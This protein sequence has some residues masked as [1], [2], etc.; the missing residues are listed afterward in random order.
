MKTQKRIKL[1]YCVRTKH[2]DDMP[3]K[4]PRKNCAFRGSGKF[5]SEHLTCEPN[6]CI[7]HPAHI[8]YCEENDIKLS[9]NF[10]VKFICVLS[11]QK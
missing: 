3:L 7:F 6:E 9:N 2:S 4:F 1:K 11:E 10:G 5:N 8:K